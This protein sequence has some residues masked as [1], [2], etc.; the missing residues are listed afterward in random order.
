[1]A[2][3]PD[4]T[5]GTLIFQEGKNIEGDF[6]IIA[7]YDDPASCTISF[8]AYELENDST[9]TH[10]FS[11]SEF[12]HL[13]RFD[14][15]LMNPSNV[16][17]RF[18]WVIERLDFVQND[19]GQKVLCLANEPTPETEAVE[20]EI[21]QPKQQG[22][23]PQAAGAG[24]VDAVTR[25]KLLKELDTHDDEKLHRG[26]V[27]SEGARKRFLAE[28]F[29][30]R[31]LEQL[32]ASQRLQRTDEEREA[33]MAK[34][35]IIKQ[36]Q[37]AKALQH[38]AN[39]EAKKSTIAQIEVL[40]KQREAQAIRR[41]IQEKDEHDRGMGREKDAARQRR[42][43]QERSA[44][45]IQAIENQRAQ[46]LARK[47]EE[48]VVKWQ[49]QLKMRDKDEATKAMERNEEERI[50]MVKRREEKDQIIEEIWRKRHEIRAER[51][52]GRELF[53]KLE[54]L[55][56]Q[57][58]EKK[59]KRRAIAER[60]RWQE[61][62]EIETEEQEA[63]EQRRRNMRNEYL[64]KWKVDSS[65]RA[66]AKRENA[67][68]ATHREKKLKEK[69]DIRLRKFRETQFLD[70]MRG[71][72]WSPTATQKGQDLGDD[73]EGKR[74]TSAD[75]AAAGPA[76][77]DQEVWAKSFEQQER[78]RRQTDR[79]DKRRQEEAKKSKVEK[80]GAANPNLIEIHRINEWRQQEE[81]KQQAV[82]HARLQRELA[83]EKV[84]KELS[85]RIEHRMEKWEYLEKLRRE[86]SLEREIKRNQAVVERTRTRPMG[87]ALPMA[88]VY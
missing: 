11:Y 62:R 54:D 88:L 32:K 79:A 40:M 2:R 14:T 72:S 60:E 76:Q 70:T 35:E 55:R 75:N 42:K 8:S 31:Q 86:R 30:K 84:H 48:Q 58:L 28:L 16:D 41:L 5:R 44:A 63:T 10:P 67:K 19:R 52:A 69:E 17:G 59:E 24:R 53:E 46:Q 51:D 50:K 37:Q 81:K 38:R 68:R 87:A 29:A 66:V 65:K 85:D 80:L 6:Y 77:A 9:Y 33:R 23:V 21:Q 71:R 73:E 45:E 74:P 26:L 3:R 20:E 43:M 7:V 36:Q 83:E 27:K 82:E 18:H 61:L 56:D 15:E 49:Q 13:F 47:R 22:M 25:A 12:D 34:L 1:M 39:E 64:L 78:Q 4:D 57:V